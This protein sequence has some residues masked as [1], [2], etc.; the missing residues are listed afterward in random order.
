MP[1]NI[2]DYVTTPEMKP[3]MPGQEDKLGNNRVQMAIPK[4]IPPMARKMMPIPNVLPPMQ[5]FI[6]EKDRSER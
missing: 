6:E 2:P 3:Y 1:L 5:A 4:V